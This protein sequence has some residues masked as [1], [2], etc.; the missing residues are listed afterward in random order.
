[1]GRRQCSLPVQS[2]CGCR[3]L[4]FR[5][6]SVPLAQRCGRC[7][8]CR[9]PNSRR[10]DRPFFFEVLRSFARVGRGP[11]GSLGLWGSSQINGARPPESIRAADNQ[12][13]SSNFFISP[14]PGM[15]GTA[16]LALPHYLQ[17]PH[18]LF[19]L[20]RNHR[21][22]RVALEVCL[23]NAR[24]NLPVYERKTMT[25]TRIFLPGVALPPPPGFVLSFL[26]GGPTALGPRSWA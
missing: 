4:L 3:V 10:K 20:V 19:S 12:G 6:A 13:L 25:K 7:R 1:V 21:P 5:G 17:I 16:R 18:I 24:W 15:M 11:A 8:S 22:H 9:R 26:I 2:R 23:N 14:V